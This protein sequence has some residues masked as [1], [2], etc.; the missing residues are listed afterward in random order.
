[1][2]AFARTLEL[3]RDIIREIA[4]G[5]LLHDV[6]KAAHP[7]RDPQQ[8]GQAHRRR[9]RAHEEPR[10]AEQDHPAGARPGISPIALDVAAQHH[11]R[12]DGTGYPN[13]LTGEAISL[14][15]QHGG[16]RGRV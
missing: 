16:D 7:R 6:G 3:P 5:A 10:G 11:E 4:I 9:V 1:M 14:Y 13:K 2:T 12:F 15:G 8:A